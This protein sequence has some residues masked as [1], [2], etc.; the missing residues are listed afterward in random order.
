MIRVLENRECL[1]EAESERLLDACGIPTILT[2]VGS[3]T[4]EVAN[5]ARRFD[6]PVA[7]KILSPDITDKSD[8]LT[9][10]RVERAV[11]CHYRSTRALVD[12]IEKIPA[13]RPVFRCARQGR[14]QPIGFVPERAV[15]PALP[16]A[17]VIYPL[18]ARV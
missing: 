2:D 18:F 9:T 14:F 8:E 1:S 13:A 16:D 12:A 4:A 3:S 15:A 6:G 7:I 5:A 17:A 11:Y 10:H